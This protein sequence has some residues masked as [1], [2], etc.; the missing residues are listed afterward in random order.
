MASPFL[1]EHMIIET[2]SLPVSSDT[3]ESLCV[4]AMLAVLDGYDRKIKRD[5]YGIVVDAVCKFHEMIGRLV[6]VNLVRSL[7][8]KTDPA[9]CENLNK[10]ASEL[11]TG[12]NLLR[13]QILSKMQ[14]VAQC[15]WDEDTIH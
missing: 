2:L 8:G 15:P 14:V 5:E 9:T 1:N 4:A 10:A 13:K 6:I 7:I 3:S 12:A 11:Q